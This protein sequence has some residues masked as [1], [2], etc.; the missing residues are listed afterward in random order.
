MRDLFA[1]KYDEALTSLDAYLKKYPDG[2][3]TPDALYRRAVCQYALSQYDVV[4]KEG[5]SWLKK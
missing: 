1:G 4:V 2:A 5:E 3:Q